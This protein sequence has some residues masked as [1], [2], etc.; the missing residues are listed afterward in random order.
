MEETECRT[1]ILH[2]LCE[3]KPS[4]QMQVG[5]TCSKHEYILLNAWFE[6]VFG[7]TGGEDGGEEWQVVGTLSMNSPPPME[8]YTV[9]VMCAVLGQNRPAFEVKINS[10]E[11]VFALKSKINGA[12]GRFEAS[13]VKLYQ[14]NIPVSNYHTLIESISQRTIK[15]DEETKL[16]YP[17]LGLWEINGGFPDR[18]LHILVEVPAP[19]GESFSSRRLC[20]R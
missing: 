17:F 7:F 8:E 3:G 15:F 1:N 6:L 9:T 11:Q 19:A 2:P 16:G 12:L 13:T 4:K 10:N 5:L 14:V 18:H 20:Y